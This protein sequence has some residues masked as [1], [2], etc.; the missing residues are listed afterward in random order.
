M[1]YIKLFEQFINESKAPSN[2]LKLGKWTSIEANDDILDG[3]D[4][5][6]VSSFMLNTGTEL[7]DYGVIINIYDDKDFSIFFDSAPIALTTHTSSQ[8]RAISQ[9][10]AEYPLPLSKLNKAE[11]DKIINDLKVQFLNENLED[12]NVEPNKKL[13]KAT[14]YPYAMFYLSTQAKNILID[15]KNSGHV[16]LIKLL[17]NQTKEIKENGE[18]SSAEIQKG[19]NLFLKILKE[20]VSYSKYDGADCS[21]RLA[22]LPSADLDKAGKYEWYND[23]E[24]MATFI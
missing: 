23:N 22:A 18:L 10:M 12:V 9:T 8:A 20:K 2:L 21:Y 15:F 5:T 24:K 19:R 11:L 13:E 1:K 6:K 3:T 4:Y 17:A 16:E 7:D 14:R